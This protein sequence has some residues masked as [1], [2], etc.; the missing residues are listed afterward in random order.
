[1]YF[2]LKSDHSEV[3]DAYCSRCL[4]WERR[5]QKLMPTG[6]NVAVAIANVPHFHSKMLK[7]PMVFLLLI[8]LPAQ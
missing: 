3:Q 1:M 4:G 2:L 5:V 8:I 7:N 6:G